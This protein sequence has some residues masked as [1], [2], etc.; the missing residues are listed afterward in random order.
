M[1]ITWDGILG[2]AVQ[3]GQLKKLVREGRLPHALLFT[4]PAGVGKRRIAE[5]LA[6]TLL[7]GQ[8]EQ[9]CGRCAG[10]IA[11]QEDT[12]PDFY[13]IVPAGTGKAA[14][15]IRIDQI[16]AMQSE[17]AR[18]P[19]LADKRVVLIDE[20]EKMNEAAENSLLKTLEEPTGRVN[21]ILITSQRSGL[22][23]TILSRCMQMS[24]GTLP[25]K[26]LAAELVR[27]GLPETQ[28]TGLAALSDGS[29]GGAL[30]LEQDDGLVL[31]DTALTFLTEVKS[32]DM[33]H[34]WAKAEELGNMPREK[35][36]EWLAYLVMLLRDF[37]VL[38]NG[39]K[40]LYNEDL[41]EKL[42]QIL[43]DF[44]VR[45]VFLWL[46]LVSLMQKRC[47]ANVNLRLQM[48]GFLIRAHEI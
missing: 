28:A 42:V 41:R 32:F 5:A 44:P 11:L 48:E 43:A 40:S 29:I 14:K 46:G 39:G 31:R 21:F 22:L 17:I 38:Y 18:L 7:C 16:R 35:L 9:A 4:G 12:H 6:A 47:L 34:I 33:E 37:L 25:R 45:R 8:G 2:H 10:C 20:A 26:M 23:D 27:R 3:V 24:F 30:R 13:R 36:L 15:I 19:L 1:E